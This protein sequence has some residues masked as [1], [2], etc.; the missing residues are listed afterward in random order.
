MHVRVCVNVHV[1]YVHE[2][3]VLCKVHSA[4]MCNEFEVC[5]LTQCH[6]LIV[7]LTKPS[8]LKQLR[9]SPW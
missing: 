1:S 9:P 5:T 4:Q 3:A 8:L 2:Y 6:A 7:S